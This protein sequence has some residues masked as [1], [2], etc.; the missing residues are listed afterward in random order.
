M[1]YG[2]APAVDAPWRKA[3]NEDS[4]ARLNQARKMDEI[5]KS[6]IVAIV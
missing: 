4:K 1:R 2:F 5:P 6:V 3:A